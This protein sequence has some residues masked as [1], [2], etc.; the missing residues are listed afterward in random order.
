[1]PAQ[2]N[3]DEV[4]I[5]KL[6]WPVQ[7]ATR[8]QVPTVGGTGITETLTIVANVR[9]DIQA[10]G[11]LTFFG[12]QQTDIPVTHKIRMRWQDYLDITH[13]I[14]RTTTRPDGTSRTETF[15]IR[16]IAEMGGRKRFVSLDVELEKAQ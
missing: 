2:Q 5:G 10:I 3:P 16:R 7:I 6:R 4:P 8:V 11:A 13:V 14:L 9:A 15:R 12:A 1:M